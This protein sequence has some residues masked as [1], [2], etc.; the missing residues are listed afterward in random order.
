VETLCWPCRSFT[1][2][3][4]AR[5]VGRRSGHII[6]TA[7]MLLL[8]GLRHLVRFVEHNCVR[9]GHVNALHAFAVGTTHRNVLHPVN[10]AM[11][12]APDRLPFDRSSDGLR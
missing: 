3:P 5:L 8:K 4:I 6:L 2:E 1:N 10:G 7:E 9:R 11:F 12:I